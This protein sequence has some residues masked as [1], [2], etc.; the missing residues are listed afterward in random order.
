MI[1]LTILPFLANA[2]TLEEEIFIL[3]V[4]CT[5]PVHYKMPRLARHQVSLPS[6]NEY[7]NKISLR[8]V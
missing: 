3:D 6:A 2:V 1:W 8:V 5:Y 7:E 4:S